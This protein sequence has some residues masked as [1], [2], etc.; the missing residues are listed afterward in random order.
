MPTTAILAMTTGE[1]AVA[2]TM[3]ITVAALV[4]LVV[5]QLFAL[6]RR[7]MELRAHRDTGAPDTDGRRRQHEA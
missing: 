5:W 6:A 3:I 4:L 7:N 2:I 1:A